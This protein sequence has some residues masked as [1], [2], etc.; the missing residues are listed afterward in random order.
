MKGLISDQIGSCLPCLRHVPGFKRNLPLVCWLFSSTPRPNPFL[1]ERE[2]PHIVGLSLIF[3]ISLNRSAVLLLLKEKGLGDEV[4]S[5]ATTN[6]MFRKQP[7][8]LI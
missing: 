7:I 6:T 1:K 2:L 4:L 3:S 8:A 5:Q